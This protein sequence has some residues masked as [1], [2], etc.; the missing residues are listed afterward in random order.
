MKTNSSSKD[1]KKGYQ[2]VLEQI[3]GIFL[4]VINTITAAS[5]IKGILILLVTFG[6][7]DPDAG[8]Y[9]IFYAVSDGFFYFLPFYLAVTASKQWKTDLFVTLM[10]PTAMLYPDILSA[11]EQE[12]TLSFLGLPIQP[13]VYHSS[14]IPVILAVGLLY[15]VEKP[16]ERYLP[17]AVKG[18]LKPILCC[19]VVLPATFLVFGPAGAWIGN[20]L[21]DIFFRIYEWNSIVAGAFMGF[22]IQ[23]MVVLGAHWSIVPVCINNIMVHGYDVVMPLVGGAVYAQAGAALAV[24]LLYRQNK[25]KRRIAFQASFAAA[26]G[27]TEPALFGVNVPLMR[28]MVAAC[29]AG[30]IGGAIAGYAGAHCNSFAF[31]SFLTCLAYMGPNFG[32][33][34]FSMAIGF[35]L[36][37][38]FTMLQ[39][40]GVTS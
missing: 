5:I 20:F 1:K 32:L 35:P 12:E 21:T 14:I 8:V 30:S 24:G 10:I 7:L 37:F 25:E 22:F 27:V 13:T 39:K 29:F 18:F 2:K 15:F 33:F 26:L 36:G 3:T 40:K 6:V 28:P 9:R 34:L 23:P 38:L 16:C 19:I 4:P 11:M 17:E 31:P